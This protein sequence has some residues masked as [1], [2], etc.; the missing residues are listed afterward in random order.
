[1]KYVSTRGRAPELPFR[2]VLLAGLA[3]DGGLYLP[4]HYPRISGD[5]LTRWRGLSYADLAAEVIGKFAD[6][7]PAATLQAICRRTYTAAVY[8]NARAA[9][10]SALASGAA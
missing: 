9:R 7:V 4:S 3:V 6:D 8:G 10:H 2:D 1:M 5:E